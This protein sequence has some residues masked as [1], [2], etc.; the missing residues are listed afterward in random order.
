MTK[1]KLLT[2]FFSAF[3][4]ALLAY[5]GCFKLISELQAVLPGYDQAISYV[6]LFL[7]SLFIFPQLV[8][9]AVNSVRHLG[10]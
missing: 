9:P 7:A 6:C 4:V 5:V 1:A 8:F 3:V 2:N 10:S